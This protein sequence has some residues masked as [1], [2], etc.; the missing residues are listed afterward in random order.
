M[1]SFTCSEY[2]VAF[3]WLIYTFGKPIQLVYNTHIQ[4]YLSSLNGQNGSGM[5]HVQPHIC[6][7]S[8]KLERISFDTKYLYPFKLLENVKVFFIK[9]SVL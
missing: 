8:Q 4:H 1:D 3:M 6:A 9:T 7:L 2:T 5:R